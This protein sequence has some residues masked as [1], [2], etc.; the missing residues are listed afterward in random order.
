MQV[1]PYPYIIIYTLTVRLASHEAKKSI[2]EDPRGKAID[3]IK[4]YNICN[5]LG[6]L[7]E[8]HLIRTHMRFPNRYICIV[9]YRPPLWTI[10]F[11]RH[12]M[13]RASILTLASRFAFATVSSWWTWLITSIEKIQ[14]RIVIQLK[15]QK[16]DMNDINFP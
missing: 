6:K 1:I 8:T 11:S 13:T 16:I 10:A 7:E 14:K 15:R 12:R 3:K 9:T 4:E 2:L 5:I